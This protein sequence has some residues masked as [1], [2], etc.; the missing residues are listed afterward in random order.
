MTR[1][2][3]FERTY[4]HRWPSRAITEY[5]ASPTPQTVKKEVREAALAGGY[6]RVATRAE[7]TA[8]DRVDSPPAVD[9]ASEGDVRP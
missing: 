6:A 4:N 2:I 1:R 9:P 3:I 7:C 5:Q 8:A